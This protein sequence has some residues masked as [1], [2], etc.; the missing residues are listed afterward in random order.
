[1]H[2]NTNLALTL[3]ALAALQVPGLGQELAQTQK[4]A[5][6][7]EATAPVL[8]TVAVL[9]FECKLAGYEDLGAQVSS[10]LTA[11]LSKAEGLLTLERADLLK[12]LSEHELGLSGI[13][14][15]STATVVGQISG[16]KVLVT[17]RIFVSGDEYML[18]TKIIGTE[19]S[20]V[21]GEVM[22]IGVNKSPV[23]LTESLSTKVARI[24]REHGEDLLA[25]QE[26]PDALVRRLAKQLEGKELP[27]VSVSITET[28]ASRRVIDPA[29]ET[30][31]IHLLRE[32]GFTVVDPAL[33]NEPAQIEI[34]GEALSEFATRRGNLIS[35]QGRVELKAVE[36]SSGKI[37][38]AD[39]QTEMAVDLGELMAAKTALQHSAAKLVERL[40]TKI[41]S[42]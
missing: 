15:P 40:I 14:K 33:A 29:A 23:D 22:R 3:L 21:F 10:S 1:M 12:L 5:E 13:V 17:G 38:T 2:M 18:V 20:R 36:R 35:C 27:T 8:Y 31:I 42:A 26:T 25:K 32:L 41:V 7:Q 34:V 24:I 9:D 6:E 4:I 39:R 37:L 16:A 11:Y 28:H 30:E 19:T